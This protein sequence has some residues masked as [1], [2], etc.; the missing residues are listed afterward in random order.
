MVNEGRPGDDSREAARRRLLRQPRSPWEEMDAAE[1]P[2]APERK[3]GFLETLADSD[4]AA[5]YGLMDVPPPRGAPD[6]R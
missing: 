4:R 3:R 2:P 1:R 5:G 6:R